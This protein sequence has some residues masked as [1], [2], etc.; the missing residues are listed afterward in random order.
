MGLAALAVATAG[1]EKTAQIANENYRQDLLSQDREFNFAIL[2]TV[3][4]FVYYMRSVKMAFLRCAKKKGVSEEKALRYYNA[5]GTWGSLGASGIKN[6]LKIQRRINRIFSDVKMSMIANSSQFVGFNEFANAVRRSNEETWFGMNS[7]L[8]AFTMQLQ[9]GDIIDR[10][11]NDIRTQKATLTGDFKQNI[12]SIIT[13]RQL[14]KLKK[15]AIKKDSQL[16]L[17]TE[18]LD[19]FIRDTEQESQDAANVNL[20]ADS[21]ISDAPTEEKTPRNFSDA[22]K[23]T[24]ARDFIALRF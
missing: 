18:N 5:I 4:S 3:L 8:N 9:T 16:V 22:G 14:E 12:M 20:Y 6:T 2:C 21:D 15:K 19:A 11:I 23:M 13:E 17:T 7:K 10:E 24:I 1:A